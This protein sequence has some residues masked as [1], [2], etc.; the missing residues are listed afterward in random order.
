TDKL[1]E[2]QELTVPFQ[3]VHRAEA[4]ESLQSVARAFYGDASRAKLLAEY[5]FRPSP[6]L[7]KG[8]RV[9]VPIDH[10]R[11]RASRLASAPAGKTAQP[12]RA[13]SP[14]VVVASAQEIQRKEAELAARVGAQL[15][16]AERL[17]KE[18]S[19]SEVPA[20][21]DKLLTEE[22][23]SETQLAEIFRL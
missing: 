11:V 4:P 13:A 8:E 7:A 3:V 12:E 18:G 17:Y 22:D 1:R 14:A 20:A 6:M 21:L 15:T 16:H 19:Y 5:N 10:V 23:P 2:G 9:V